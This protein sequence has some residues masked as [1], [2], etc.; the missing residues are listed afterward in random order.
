MPRSPAL[1]WA[2]IFPLLVA[3]T[4]VRIDRAERIFDGRI[5]RIADALWH[6]SMFAEDISFFRASRNASLTRF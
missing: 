4:V 6:F 5:T 1:I 3:V 2:T